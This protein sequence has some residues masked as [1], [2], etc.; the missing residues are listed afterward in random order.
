MNEEEFEQFV[1]YALR[2][3]KPLEVSDEEIREFLA[4]DPDIPPGAVEGVRALFLDKVF[5]KLHPRPVWQ[6]QDNQRFSPWFKA[7]RRSARLPLE[8]ISAAI[9]ET[10]S[11]MEQLE[12][13]EI[14]PWHLNPD[15]V[16]R[17]MIVYRVHFMAI[18]RLVRNAEG[19]TAAIPPLLDGERHAQDGIAAM[20]GKQGDTRL[21]DEAARW[22]LRLREVLQSRR[23][24]SLLEF[25][26][27]MGITFD[28]SK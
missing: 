2:P 18:E 15:S 10:P 5:H 11:F 4:P 23:A 3:R 1:R 27:Y 21:V 25:R 26:D 17:L 14:P 19:A 8:E 9:E 22:L 24:R 12:S 13:G 6:V 28:S 16:A 7:V 20:L